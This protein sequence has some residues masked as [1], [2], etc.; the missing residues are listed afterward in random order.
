[1]IAVIAPL[2]WEFDGLAESLK[3][4]GYDVDIDPHI[5][6]DVLIG[7]DDRFVFAQGGHGKV[8][9]ALKCQQLLKS[10]PGVE[11]IVT[12]GIAG[13][14]QDTAKPLDLFLATEIIEHDYKTKFFPKPPPRFVLDTSVQNKIISSLEKKQFPWSQGV[15]MS[16]DEDIVEPSRISHLLNL[17][18]EA[19]AVCWEGAGGVRAAKLCGFSYAELRGFSDNCQPKSLEDFKEITTEI[20]G[21]ISLVLLSI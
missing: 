19:Q 13:A 21:R 6:Q 3:K 7:K 16:G 18:S 14:L 12:V 17:N 2:K 9:H 4:Y 20:M 10:F 8:Q 15:L 1:M 5:G 11:F